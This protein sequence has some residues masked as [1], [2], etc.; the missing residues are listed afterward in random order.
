MVPAL[1]LAPFVGLAVIVGHV[2]LLLNLGSTDDPL[3]YTVW[4]QK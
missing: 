2:S 3:G 4:I 1:V